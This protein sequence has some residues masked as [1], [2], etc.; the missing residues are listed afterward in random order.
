MLTVKK[1]SLET[2]KYGD[3]YECTVK[4]QI[5]DKS[6]NTVEITLPTTATREIIDLVVRKATEALSIDGS[7][8]RVAGEPLPLVEPVPDP[9]FAEVEE[10]VPTAA[11][12]AEAAIPTAPVAEESF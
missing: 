12:M 10:Y 4:Y 3:G 8:V 7:G 6:Y 11:P 5:G 1:I 9:E 2:E